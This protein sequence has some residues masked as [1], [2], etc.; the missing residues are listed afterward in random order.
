MFVA[1]STRCFGDQPFAEACEQLADL[2]F[3]R[4]EVWI[5]EAGRHL[6]IDD[7]AAQP[8]AFAARYREITRIPL[9]AFCLDYDAPPAKF[10]GL[11]KT[12]KLMRVTQVTV[13]AAPHGTPFNSEIDRLKELVRVALL[14][15]VRVSLKTER[16]R[17]TDDLHTAA[18]LCQ[19]VQGL[20]LTFDPSYSL[21][22]PEKTVELVLPRVFHVHL[23][24]S[25]PDQVQVQ[26][27]LG[28]VDYSGLITNLRRHHYNRAL[29]VE[30][31]PEL[32][33]ADQRPLELRKLRMLLDSLL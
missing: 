18:E 16:G 10:A 2:E 20:G 7:V 33:E 11:C 9:S 28:E 30:W 19:A 29:S 31:L 27:G 6:P 3:E 13:P 22:A 15:G 21:Q 8:E 1:A 26:V 17:L 12:A 25:T 23:R 4:F 24:D 14:E 5:D 32:G